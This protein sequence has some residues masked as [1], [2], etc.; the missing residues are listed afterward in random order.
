MI[1][2]QQIKDEFA[3]KGTNYSRLLLIIDFAQLY[4]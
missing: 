4:S 2:G 3:A 1:L